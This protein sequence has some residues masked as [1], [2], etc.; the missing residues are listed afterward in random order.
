MENK[1]ITIIGKDVIESLTLGMYE[2]ALIIYREYIQNSADAIDKAVK[3]GLLPSRSKGYINIEIDYEKRII[4]IEDIGI[5]IKKDESIDILK[6]IASSSKER[7]IDKGFRG[8]GR[9]GGLAYC[10]KLIFETS[11]SGEETKTLMVWD[12]KLLKDILNDRHTK[13]TAIEV[14][15]KVTSVTFEKENKEKH[16]FKVILQNVNNDNLLD[17]KKIKEYLEMVAPIPYRPAFKIYFKEFVEKFVSEVSINE[18]NISINA[19]PLEKPYKTDI[20]DDNDKWKENDKITRLEYFEVKD[21]EDLLGFGWYGVSSFSG[22]LSDKNIMRGIRLRKHNIQIGDEYTLLKFHK[23]TKRGNLYFIGEVHASHA[24]LIPNARRDYFIPNN[25]V[26]NFEKA[27]KER[28]EELHQKF[29]YASNLRSALKSIEQPEKEASVLAEKISKNDFIDYS[30]KEKSIKDYHEKLKK[31][32]ENKKKFEKLKD[33]AN[34]DTIDSHIF[35]N[36]VGDKIIDASQNDT[37]PKPDFNASDS[38]PIVK[39]PSK[40]Y[41][42]IELEDKINDSGFWTDRLSQLNKNERKLVGEV[43]SIIVQNLPDKKLIESLK[44][45]LLDYYAK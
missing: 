32:E 23:D 26:E 1:N 33:K 20:K 45:K 16:Y 21:N 7:G 42:K 36:I 18:Y 27:L 35:K 10:D 13:E 5:G 41:N 40:I 38:Y 8:I 11:Y 37:I 30:D 15:E 6:N 17:Y 22:V 39:E 34:L 44:Q 14:I 43:F 31:A 28:F 24:D 9:L 12:A 19:A 2:N 25:V 3:A 4:Y 29:Y